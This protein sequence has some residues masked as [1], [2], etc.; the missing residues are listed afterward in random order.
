MHHISQGLRVGR[1]RFFFIVNTITMHVGERSQQFHVGGCG[2]P[3]IAKC[4]S[5]GGPGVGERGSPRLAMP[6]GFGLVSWG[7]W[8]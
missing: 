3:G 7:S 5:P 8:T 2:F 6:A 1:G 4:G